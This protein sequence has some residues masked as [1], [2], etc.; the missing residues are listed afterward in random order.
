MEPVVLDA[1]EQHYCPACQ[2]VK[3]CYVARY[4]REHEIRCTDCFPVYYSA[5]QIPVK[6]HPDVWRYLN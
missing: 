5:D 6:V 4:M 1:W 2:E 3:L